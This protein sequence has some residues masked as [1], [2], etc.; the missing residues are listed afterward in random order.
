MSHGF[1]EEKTRVVPKKLLCSK[2]KITG[3]IFWLQCTVKL[4]NSLPQGTAPKICLG[5]KKAKDKFME[6]RF[7]DGYIAQQPAC[8]LFAQKRSNKISLAFSFSCTLLWPTVTGLK[9]QV[10][11]DGHQPEENAQEWLRR[12]FCKWGAWG[13]L[14][15]TVGCFPAATGL[16]CNPGKV[17]SAEQCFG[18]SSESAAS[19]PSGSLCHGG[20]QGKQRDL[21]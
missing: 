1:W 13:N 8:S 2:F 7:P 15:K 9:R 18:C 6:I 20:T 11:E 21:H 3:N 10:E 19:G 4:G 17:P 12:N 5:S 14:K 16:L